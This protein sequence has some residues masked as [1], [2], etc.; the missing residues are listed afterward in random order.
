MLT[1][2]DGA[3]KRPMGRS[4]VNIIVDGNGQRM[5]VRSVVDRAGVFQLLRCHV[6]RRPHD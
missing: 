6:P 1:L 3:A 5:D 4:P 2:A